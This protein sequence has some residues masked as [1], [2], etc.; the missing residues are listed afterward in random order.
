MR[1]HLGEQW[2]ARGFPLLVRDAPELRESLFY[3]RLFLSSRT[4]SFVSALLGLVLS[5]RTAATLLLA[6]PYANALLR[7]LT[8][9]PLRLRPRM[10]AAH[11][12]SDVI[13]ALALV[14]G[15]LRARRPVL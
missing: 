2:L 10:F 4:A 1:N 5:K 7:T 3:R 11:L 6:L 9:G 12:A 8:T 13:T 15:S 14:Y